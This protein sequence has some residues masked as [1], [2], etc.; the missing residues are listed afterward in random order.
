[1]NRFPGDQ[2][3]WTAQYAALGQFVVEFEWICW[4][5]RF[6]ACAL[7]QMHG[8]KKWPLAEVIM[9]QRVFTADPLFACYASMVAECL[10]SD[11]ALIKELDALRKEFQE[12]CK[13]RNDLLHAS[14][15]IG[16]DVVEISDKEAPSEV[17]AE[18]RTPNKHG[19]RVQILART[20]DEQLK[21]VASATAVKE[22][23]KQFVPKVVVALQNDA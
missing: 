2:R 12:L 20:I 19:A 6:H 22:K 5:L 8:L 13:T 9:N 4:Y 7:L 1:M 17:H 23:V 21:Y 11:H 16:G 18:K 15:L 14:Y 3:D 10:G